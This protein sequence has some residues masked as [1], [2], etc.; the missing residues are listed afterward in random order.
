M[1]HAPTPLDISGKRSFVPE[2]P[3]SGPT[4]GGVRPLQPKPTGHSFMET[5][6]N[7]E[8]PP[9]KKKRGRPTKAET[10]ARREAAVARGESYPALKRD[11]TGRQSLVGAEEGSSTL[12]SPAVP[13]APPITTPPRPPTDPSE[14]SSGKRRRGRSSRVEMEAAQTEQA[15]PTI[16]A[17]A[18]PTR[19]GYPDILHPNPDPDPGPSTRPYQT[20]YAEPPGGYRPP[21]T[22]GPGPNQPG[23]S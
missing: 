23:P 9:T 21:E 8:E 6:V 4:S 2:A 19:R 3:H 18:T 20:P 5:V 11:S 1:R 13:P 10:Q 12:A 22:Q 14:T 15:V 17:A 16:A 7:P